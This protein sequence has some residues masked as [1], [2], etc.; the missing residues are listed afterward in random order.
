M[1]DLIISKS[2][3][4]YG[5]YEFDKQVKC[6]ECDKRWYHE[7]PVG[8]GKKVYKI[9]MVKN[10]L[11]D[12]VIDFISTEHYCYTCKK[13]TEYDFNKANIPHVALA[14]EMKKRDPYNCP[15]TGERVPYVFKKTGNKNDLQYQK[16]EDPKYLMDNCIPIDF[17]YY[18]QHQ[19]KSA[20]DT[21]FYPILKEEMNKNYT[22]I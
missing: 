15:I 13:E 19:F 16:V 17:E 7:S 5:S 18:F 4:G 6:K 12:S 20:L 22:R 10:K 2:L 1:E 21:I 9:P 11:E 8:S 3:K 14:R